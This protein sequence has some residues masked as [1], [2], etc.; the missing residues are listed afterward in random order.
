MS[1]TD[2]YLHKGSGCYL[3]VLT[4]LISGGDGRSACCCYPSTSS[5]YHG[6]VM[7]TI[8]GCCLGSVGANDGDV[9]EQF[10]AAA[11]QGLHW[12]IDGYC[13]VCVGRWGYSTSRLPM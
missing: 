8:G 6:W 3:R 11:G 12:I 13:S 1:A 5:G 10:A 7:L 9:S 4:L 2:R